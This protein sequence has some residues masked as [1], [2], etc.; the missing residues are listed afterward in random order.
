[1]ENSVKFVKFR[2]LRRFV[3]KETYDYLSFIDFQIFTIFNYIKNI[4]VLRFYVS[5]VN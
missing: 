2:L 4:Y 5:S 1:M 3:V